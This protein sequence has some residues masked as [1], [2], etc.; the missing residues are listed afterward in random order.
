[1]KKRKNYWKKLS[2]ILLV[3]ALSITSVNA[4]LNMEKVKAAETITEVH[5][6]VSYGQTEAR[7]MLKMLNEFRQSPDAWE[8]NED[9]TTKITHTDLK[10]LTYDYTLEKIAM[11]RA[12]EIALVFSHTRPNGER[13]FTAYEP[14]SYSAKAENIAAGY[15][16]AS[17]VFAGWQES[18]E[19]Y[20][21]QGHRRNMLTEKCSAIGIG[22]VYYNGRHYWVQEF[23]SAPLDT[24]ETTAKDENCVESVAI[25]T[26]SISELSV[27]VSSVKV[28][29]NTEFQL[30]NVEIR[31]KIA[32]HWPSVDICIIK[33]AYSFSSAD[34]SILKVQNGTLISGSPGNTFLKLTVLDREIMIP[35][36]VIENLPEPTPTIAPTSTPTIAP[37]STP[38]IASTSTPT[39][40]PSKTPATMAPTKTPVPTILPTATPP[41]QQSSAQPMPTQ[42]SEPEATEIPVPT[43][44]V[45]LPVTV[46]PTA[47]PSE[48]NL[49][50]RVTAVKCT[51]KKKTSRAV[52]KFAKQKNVSGYELVY[53][54]NKKFTRQCKRKLL[55]KNTVNLKLKRRKTYYIKVRAYQIDTAGKKRYG[56]Y[57][58]VVKRKMK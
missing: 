40:M 55:K 3:C 58:K 57:S 14:Y 6:E 15:S 4:V 21:G 43:E 37:T 13:C 23:G 36:T 9:N 51:Q 41:Q 42:S 29:E 45:T 8:W 48:Q 22:H 44:K 27:N 50:K 26:D 31:A 18:D 2:A 34:E 12:L 39:I 16:S 17:A 20:S 47:T 5:I 11:K 52:V 10:V 46:V 53:A 1:M 30:E 54:M 24:E 49:I 38:T 19:D 28:P 32:E 33:N 56:K 35:V 25:K 7:S